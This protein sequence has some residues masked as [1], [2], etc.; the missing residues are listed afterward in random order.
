[1]V[2]YRA[3]LSINNSISD[4][5]YF[6]NLFE[7]EV[8]SG[9]TSVT[10]EVEIDEEEIKEIIEDALTGETNIDISTN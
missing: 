10:P 6:E 3:I 9:D 1:M 7:P 2:E 8:V 5:V 4:I